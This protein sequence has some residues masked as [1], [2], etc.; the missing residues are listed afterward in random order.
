MPGVFFQK[1]HSQQ[2]AD[3]VVDLPGS[4]TRTAVVNDVQK[5][6]IS[7]KLRSTDRDMDVARSLLQQ[8]I[9][10][11]SLKDQE[12]IGLLYDELV[13]LTHAPS[14]GVYQWN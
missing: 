10:L 3:G 11:I 7:F 13:C 8:N 6:L 12:V 1:R 9:H 4:S 2:M 5:T 14:K